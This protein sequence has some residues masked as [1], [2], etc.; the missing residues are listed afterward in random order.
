MMSD[1]EQPSYYN[2]RTWHIRNNMGQRRTRV[3]VRRLLDGWYRID[4]QILDDDRYPG[5]VAIDFPS[6]VWVQMRDWIADG[7][8]DPSPPTAAN[9]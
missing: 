8:P 4:Q 3:T 9:P 2:K 7:C 5:I 1:E 6:E